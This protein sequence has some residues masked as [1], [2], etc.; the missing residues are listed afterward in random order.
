MS[1]INNVVPKKEVLAYSGDTEWTDALLPTSDRA[2]LFVC[3]CYCF[4]KVAPFHIDWRTLLA[5]LPEI[6]A[7]RLL[8]THM[9]A[10]MLA[11]RGTV[12]HPKV[13]CADDGMVVDL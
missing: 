7:R 8:L 11:A 1:D 12:S 9:G 3:E 5:K 6:T 13:T 4:D 10:A 2:D